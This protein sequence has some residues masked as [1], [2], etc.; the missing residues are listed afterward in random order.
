MFIQCV[1]YNAGSTSLIARIILLINIYYPDIFCPELAASNCEYE[2]EY[3]TE[4]EKENEDEVSR[5]YLSVC[6]IGVDIC[7]VKI[8]S[9]IMRASKL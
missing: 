8:V 1:Y 7:L 6:L 9:H 5:L 3:E 4:T 2:C